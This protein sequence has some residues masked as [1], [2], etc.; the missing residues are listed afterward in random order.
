[1]GQFGSVLKQALVP[2]RSRL[3]AAAL[4]LDL[5]L[6][7]A[8]DVILESIGVRWHLTEAAVVLSSRR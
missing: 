6:V 5:T 8:Q 1:M 4:V 7:L 3:V 2:T